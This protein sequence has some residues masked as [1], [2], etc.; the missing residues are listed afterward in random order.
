MCSQKK[1]DKIKQVLTIA[2]GTHI[3]LKMG[4]ESILMVLMISIGSHPKG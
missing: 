1:L 2:N 4:S 3:W